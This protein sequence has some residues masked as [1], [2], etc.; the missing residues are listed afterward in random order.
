MSPQ[1]PATVVS[2]TPPPAA[3]PATQAAA[4]PPTDDLKTL[5][6]EIAS[7]K[8]T[9]AEHQR[10]AQFWYEKA[11]KGAAVE[12][13]PKAEP[14][15]AEPEVDLLDLITTQ[16]AKG[17]TA[18][19]KKQGLVT[20]TESERYAE[21]LVNTKAAQLSAEQELRGEYPEL[22]NEKSDFFLATAT[23]YGELKKQGVPEVTA[24]R[25]AAKSAELD[26]IRAG[27]IKTPAQKRSDQEAERRTRAAAGAGDR[28]G[29]TPQGAEDDDTLSA[30]DMAAVRNLAEALEI[31][32]ED[33]QKRYV[34][35]AKAGVNVALKL[36]RG[37]R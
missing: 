19:L 6:D 25:L 21:N 3:A 9:V 18:Y 27:T 13:K 7:L 8:G 28:G 1:V 26:G 30:D 4:A 35:R 22:G 16:G 10:N 14:E 15:Q 12:P 34:A 20:R 37:N 11:A 36:D 17:L 33:A 23:H 2:A 5:R 24:M 31:P 29:R 32:V